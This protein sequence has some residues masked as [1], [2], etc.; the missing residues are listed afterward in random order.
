MHAPRP[1]FTCLVL[2]LSFG[3]LSGCKVTSEDIAYWK[4]TV[5][6]PGKI[7]AVVLAD[8]YDLSLRTEA[9]LALIEMERTDEDG[10][11]LLQQAIQ[12]LARSDED[13]THA[14]VDGMAPGLITLMEGEGAEQDENLGPPLQ[15]IR[16]KDAAYF[17][18]SHAT[19]ETRPNLVSAVVRWYSRDFANRSLSGNY[20][21]EQVVR[22]LG[23]PAARQLVDAMSYEVPQQALV[24]IAE[25]IGQI[26]DDETKR[27]A[28]ARL[29]EIE[30]AMEGQEFI[31]WLKSKINE[32]LESQ[33]READDGRVT[34]IA[35]VNR[36]G[37]INTGAIP[38]MKHLA[39]V[40]AVRNRLMVIALAAPSAEMNATSQEAINTRRQRA[41]MALQGNATEAQLS[42]LLDLALSDPAV[43]DYAFDRIGD[44][45]SPDAI[46]R[47]WPLVE[48]GDNETNR[49]RWRAG[50]LVLSLGGADVV[51]EFLSK[52]PSD[53]DADYLPQELE[54][55]ATQMSQMTPQPVEVIERQL[56]AREWYRR[57][58]ALNFIAR[59][60]TQADIAKMQRL[61]SD[62]TP[63]VGDGWEGRE[64]ETVG[65]V[66][67][68]AI[69]ALRERLAT[70]AEAAAGEASE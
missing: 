38:A 59:R 9:G 56:S 25:L 8:R 52:L 64:I 5:K 10:V 37:F 60:G 54:G 61:V 63:V 36:E 7:V 1:L 43:Q 41:L 42:Q 50:E 20:S 23:P 51:T 13:A 21:V 3:A 12:R 46:P 65:K 29:V 22:S 48:N 34:N 4:G 53:S 18:I 17:L 58:I 68:A 55:Y 44:I 24:K 67:E 11:E 15:Q 66:A 39:G 27:L 28:G 31:D 6:G 33:G 40:E 47:L 57:V 32:S 49:Q 26:G 70:P 62:R 16:A 69:A 2:A 14:I 45:R 30:T 35:L 19:P